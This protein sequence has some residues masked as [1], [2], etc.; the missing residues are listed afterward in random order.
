MKLKK[1]D[2]IHLIILILFF[3]GLG[4]RVESMGMPQEHPG[5]LKAGNAF[6][7]T[8]AASEV[9]NGA[10]P[11]SYPNFLAG[12]YSDILNI[13]SQHQAFTIGSLINLTGI[14]DWKLAILIVSLISA[15]SIPL[16]YLLTKKLFKIESIAILSA[17]LIAIPFNLNHWLYT[18]YIGIWLQSSAMTFIVASLLFAYISYEN[19][20]TWKILSLGLISAA[21]FLLFPIALIITLPAL[22][23][24]LI[25]LIKKKN[26]K[27]ILLYTLFPVIAVIVAM[28][29]YYI[30]YFTN[31]GYT[32][33]DNTTLE[34][35]LQTLPFVVHFDG[36]P[37]I[38]TIL[39]GIGTL[40]LLSNFKKN[41]I[42][43]YY[44]A[45]YFTLIFLIVRFVPPGIMT[46]ILRM[47]STLPYFVLPIVA[48]GIILIITAISKNTKINQ[49]HLIGIVLLSFLILG[50]VQS[51]NLSKAISNE[52]MHSEKYEAMLWI[53][54]NTEEDDKI[55]M[56]E[57]SY[58][59][60]AVY[61]KRLTYAV[62][63]QELQNKVSKLGNTNQLDFVFDSEWSD[64]GRWSKFRYKTGYLSYDSYDAP[65]NTQDIRD[66]DYIY[67]ENLNEVVAQYNQI[68]AEAL[69]SNNN[70]K[71][72]YGEGTIVILEK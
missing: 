65:N 37:L 23:A 53:Q 31:E 5:N 46:Y 61:T 1:R 67:L 13:V 32:T 19:P 25:K 28:P 17:A 66:F 42:P 50:L 52:H 58:Q 21:L 9:A 69:I 10:P 6:Y 47:W 49:K 30:G 26:F 39:F 20:K 59:G 3:I 22:I 7:H 48:Y 2:L 18:T 4:I 35:K 64:V 57:G 43:I 14:E 55:F 54:E 15:L 34:E 62:P 70:F 24:V 8:I 16:M 51:T 60:E 45:Y 41:K 63:I 38:I 11:F 12:G 56:L 29:F 33:V 68:M 27:K 44:L 40:A 36:F 72:V 71:L